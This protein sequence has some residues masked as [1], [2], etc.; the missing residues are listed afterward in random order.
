MGLR[1]VVS[2]LSVAQA[3]KPKIAELNKKLTEINVD[4]NDGN[5]F[6]D[7]NSEHIKKFAS[8]TIIC[9]RWN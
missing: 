3:A 4:D 2:I 5:V 6:D 1:I 8:K 9:G 7:F